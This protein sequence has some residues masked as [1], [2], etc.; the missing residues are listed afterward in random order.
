MNIYCKNCGKKIHYKFRLLRSNSKIKCN[1]CDK[2]YTLDDINYNRK[3]FYLI[4]VPLEMILIAICLMNKSIIDFIVRLLLSVIL[5]NFIEY[6]FISF[7]IRKNGF[8]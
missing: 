5:V 2:V 1:Y 6:L 7:S 8:K 4:F 3:T